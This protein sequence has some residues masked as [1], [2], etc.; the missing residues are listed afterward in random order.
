MSNI[1]LQERNPFEILVRNFL[2][3]SANFRPVESNIKLSHPI[4]I[5]RT[6]EGLSLDIACTG[7]DK[8]EI[9]INIEGNEIKFNYQKP[10]IPEEENPNEY[11]FRGI[12]KRSFNFGYK[13]D[14]RYDL[15]KSEAT[16][17]NGLLT[18]SI[19]FASSAKPKVLKIK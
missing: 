13:I 7:I 6:P 8:N 16:F 18:V 4:D 15:S 10:H 17:N 1:F 19:P 14:S 12:A 2:E 3:S 11:V 9:D 5:Y